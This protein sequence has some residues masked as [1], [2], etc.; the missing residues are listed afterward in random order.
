ML[1]LYSQ[2]T[3]YRGVQYDVNRQQSTERQDHHRHLPWRLLHQGGKVM[4]T[5]NIIK[6]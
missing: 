1:N 5:L 3:S 2:L 6:T 4:N